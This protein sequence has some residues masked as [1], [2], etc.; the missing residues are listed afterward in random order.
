MKY[1]K[2][3]RISE[4]IVQE[5]F[6]ALWE[7]DVLLT[8]DYHA[9]SFLYLS[10]RNKALNFLKHQKIEEKHLVQKLG[11]ME[12]ERF[13]EDQL[14]RHETIRIVNDAISQLPDQTRKVILLGL[15]GLKNKEIASEIG[16]SIDT[17]KYH[18]T[19]AY[20][21][22]RKILKDRLWILFIISG[23]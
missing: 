17:V 7:S 10:C 1:V 18:K 13:Y 16:I 12:S 14:I 8:E 21:T 4:D 19:N 2:D 9:R 20:K 11:D 23:L 6:V 15:E 22:L 5:S 3:I